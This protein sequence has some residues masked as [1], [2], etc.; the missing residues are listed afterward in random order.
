MV[1][2]VPGTA[3]TLNALR[4]AIYANA[5]MKGWWET[6]R[7]MAQSLVLVVSELAEAVEA[8]REDRIATHYGADSPSKPEGVVAELADAV[9]RLLD[10]AGRFGIEQQ[11]PD[12]IRRHH[13]DFF[14]D[15]FG[16]M[17]RVVRLREDY[18]K[19]AIPMIENLAMTWVSRADFWGTVLEKHRYNLG[20][21]Y[22]HGGKKA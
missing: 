18:P 7:S 17:A 1:V 4:D 14:P 20:R 2:L 11:L 12:S 15:M 22:R 5:K 13:G 6:E 10:I 16:I 8:Y 21:E 19:D 9:I 3:S